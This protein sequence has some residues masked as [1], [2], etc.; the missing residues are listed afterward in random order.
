MKSIGYIALDE[1]GEARYSPASVRWYEKSE[2]RKGPIKIYQSQKRAE[3][4]SPIGKAKE[5]FI[6]E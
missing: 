6:Y 5:V 3:S 1:E 2:S 4:I